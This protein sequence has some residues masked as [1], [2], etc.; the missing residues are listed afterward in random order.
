MRRQSLKFQDIFID[1]AGELRQ[2]QDKQTD[3]LP[4]VP[5]SNKR[6]TDHNK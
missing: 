5:G 4:A 6:S 3:C 1:F 2:Q